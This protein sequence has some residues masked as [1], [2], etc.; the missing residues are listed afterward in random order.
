MTNGLSSLEIG[1]ILVNVVIAIA[2]VVFNLRAVRDVKDQTRFVINDEVRKA[3]R[4]LTGEDP[5]PEMD[6]ILDGYESQGPAT[7]KERVRRIRELQE[8]SQLYKRAK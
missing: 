8:R 7:Y 3:Y 5:G 2:S 4:E 1:A 6:L